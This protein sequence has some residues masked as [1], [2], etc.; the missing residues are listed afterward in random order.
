M[1]H[2][3]IYGMANRRLGTAYAKEN[4][5]RLITPIDKSITF[6]IQNIYLLVLYEQVGH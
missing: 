3:I 1:H 6:C 2:V 4:T 5:T